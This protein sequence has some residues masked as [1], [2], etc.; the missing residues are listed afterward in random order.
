MDNYAILT[1]DWSHWATTCTEGILRE[2]C[3]FISIV[4]SRPVGP[5]GQ[6]VRAVKIQFFREESQAITLLSRVVMDWTDFY[7][8]GSLHAASGGGGRPENITRACPWWW[9][10]GSSIL[11]WTRLAIQCNVFLLYFLSP[12]LQHGSR[13]IYRIHYPVHTLYI[14]HVHYTYTLG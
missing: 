9:D 1:M 3:L 14:I 8:K 11:H 13:L 5:A 7:W 2:T 12:K 6:S 4:F 10:I